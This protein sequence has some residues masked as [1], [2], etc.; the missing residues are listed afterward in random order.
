MN[1]DKA[2]VKAI[3]ADMEKAMQL[4]ADLHGVDYQRKAGTFTSTSLN[5][6]GVFSVVEK[7]EGGVNLAS[8]EAAAFTRYAASEGIDPD[9]LGKTVT[10]GGYEYRIVGFRPKASKFPI[11]V[12]RVSDGKRMAFTAP[13]VTRQYP[14][15]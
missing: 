5:V 6:R 1:M 8:P 7:G 4:V 13:I 11:M 2:L 10:Y 12:E 15:G 3:V 9:A 14:K